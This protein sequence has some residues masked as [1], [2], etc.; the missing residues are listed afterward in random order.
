MLV[1]SVRS[2]WRNTFFPSIRRK[3]SFAGDN[4]WETSVMKMV[5]HTN[6]V[7]LHKVERC[8][9]VLPRRERDVARTVAAGHHGNKA[10]VDCVLYCKGVVVDDVT[11]GSELGD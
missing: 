1:Y 7:E 5:K 10:F 6:T 4:K 3:A 2:S 9:Q 11:G 8:S